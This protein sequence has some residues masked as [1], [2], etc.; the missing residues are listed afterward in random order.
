MKEFQEIYGRIDEDN[1]S[2]HLEFFRKYV[3]DDRCNF[4][5]LAYAPNL[6][7]YLA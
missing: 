7:E 4:M 5:L 2:D 6:C 1:F 3:N